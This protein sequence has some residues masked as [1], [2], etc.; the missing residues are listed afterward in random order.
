[1]VPVPKAAVN[2]ND[3]ST[4]PKDQIRASRQILRVQ[5]I[6]V[7]E[8]ENEPADDHLWSCVTRANSR[9]DLGAFFRRQIVHEKLIFDKTKCLIYVLAP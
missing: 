8:G 5:P 4:L 9:H 7:A 6:P 1:M 2:K 3:L